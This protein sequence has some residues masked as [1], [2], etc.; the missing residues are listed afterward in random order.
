LIKIIGLRVTKNSIKIISIREI[1]K[2]QIKK[3]I[4]GSRIGYL[5]K[6]SNR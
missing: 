4:K 2:R 5:T 6:R 3:S 1:I